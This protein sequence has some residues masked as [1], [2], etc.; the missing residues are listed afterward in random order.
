MKRC[1]IFQNIHNGA[2]MS[3]NEEDTINITGR[4]AYSSKIYA[5]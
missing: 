2:L 3:R 5:T 4:A 1:A